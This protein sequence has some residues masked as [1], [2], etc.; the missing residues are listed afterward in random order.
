MYNRLYSERLK[1]L[2]DYKAKLEREK[3]TELDNER[4][5]KLD[6]EIENLI[7][8]ERALFI[9]EEKGYADQNLVKSEHEELVKT[10]TLLQAERSDWMAEI[11]KRD[12]RLARTLELEAVLDAQGGNLIEFSDDLYRKI[13][14]KIVVKN[15]P[16]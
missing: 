14:E 16:N 6:E 2:G 3:F 15:E 12:N 7:R 11:N 8:Q 13:V 4:I 10:L 5:G 1:L 9:I